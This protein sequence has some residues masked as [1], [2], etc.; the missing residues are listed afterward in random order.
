MYGYFKQEGA[1]RPPADPR[2]ARRRDL[3]HPCSARIRATSTRRQ[4]TLANCPFHALASEHTDL[5]CGMNLALMDAVVARLGESKLTATL[6]SAPGRCC[7]VL[8]TR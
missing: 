8:T 1:G 4:V 2:N 6:D 3:R 7:V 5:V